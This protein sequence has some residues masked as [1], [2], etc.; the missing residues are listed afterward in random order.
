MKYS[1]L[2]DSRLC[3]F[4]YLTTFQFTF[5]QIVYAGELKVNSVF[6]L[7]L[8]RRGIYSLATITSPNNMTE[9]RIQTL[10]PDK[11]KQNKIISAEKYEVIKAAIL[12]ILQEQ[13]LTHTQ[14]MQALHD[15]VHATFAGNAHW[16]GE[17]VKL[18]LEARDIIKRNTAKPPVYSIHQL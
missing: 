8:S 17:T 11:E 5:N 15:K 1:V 3:N 9:A 4:G 18:D 10:H 6:F 16:Y 2:I 7:T 13:S 12:Q 14:L